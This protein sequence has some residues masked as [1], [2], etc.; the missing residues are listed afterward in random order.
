SKIYINPLELFGRDN[1]TIGELAYLSYYTKKDSTHTSSASDWFF[2]IYSKPYIGGPGGIEFGHRIN[3]KP[4]FSESLNEPA[5]TW[6][7]WQTDADIDN[8]LRFYDSSFG[9]FGGYSDPF[10]SDFTSSSAYKNQ[11]I[12]Y[13]A[14]GTD[15]AW[16]SGFF[17]QL[18]GLSIMLANGDI[19]KVNFESMPTPGALILAGIGIGFVI[20]LRKQRI[21]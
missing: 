10:L 17:G 3:S 21:L 9:Y 8:R 11:E 2:Q 16:A 1:V 19:A 13:I 18:D 5:Y 7:L 12:L 6:N 15:S 20:K 14:V 4:Y